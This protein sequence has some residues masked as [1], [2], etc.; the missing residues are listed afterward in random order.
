MSVTDLDSTILAELVDLG[1]VEGMELVRELVQIFFRE[2]RERMARL[3]TGLNEADSH[4]V[5]QAAHAMRGG[6]AGLGAV[7]LANLCAAIERQART[8]NLTGLDAEFTA[9]VDGLPGLEER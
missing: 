3:S 4:K 9:I 7:G 1:P 8:G 2:A 6:A 5:S